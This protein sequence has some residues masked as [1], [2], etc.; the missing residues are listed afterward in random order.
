M[1]L[2]FNRINCYIECR[3]I[4]LN[5]FMKKGVLMYAELENVLGRTFLE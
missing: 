2:I 4:V 1:L 3:N 5:K